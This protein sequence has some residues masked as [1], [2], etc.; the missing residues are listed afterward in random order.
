MD[1]NGGR[2]RFVEH[3]GVVK[4]HVLEEET[5]LRLTLSKPLDPDAPWKKISVRPVLAGGRRQ[6]QFSYFDGTKDVARNCDG[7]E[8]ERRLDE[9]LDM[10]FGQIQV[11]ATSGDLTVLVSAKGCAHITKSKPSRHEEAPVLSHDRDKHLPLP[12]SGGDPLLRA[13]GI[14]AKRGKQVRS[15]M[16]GK[17]HQINEFL[18]VID[19]VIEPEAGAEPLR[20]VDCGCGSAYLTFAAYHYL[21]HRRNI[22]ARVTGV[23]ANEELIAKCVKLRDSLKWDGIEF[24]VSTIAEFEPDVPPDVVLSLHACDTATDEAIARGIGWESGVILAAPCCQHELHPQLKA[25]ALRALLRHGI[26]R[27]RLAD[28]VTDTFRALALRIMGYRTRVLEF[29]PPESTSKNLMIR[30]ERGLEPGDPAF[31]EEY[32]ALKEFW[33]VTPAIEGLLGGG[34]ERRLRPPAG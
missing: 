26:L 17:F 15:A 33:N 22:P 25:P 16:R 32:A 14:L 1:M 12:A 3:K 8:A 5:F 34:F 24:R 6:M 20:I 21:T 7:D 19:Q 28:L 27:E 30:A 29:V 9:A 4:G 11:Q 31:V 23:D 10:P 13:L 18:R 2:D